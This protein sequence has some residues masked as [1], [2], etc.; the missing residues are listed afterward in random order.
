MS[1]NLDSLFV[2]TVR[3]VS[4]NGAGI[5]YP[6][7]GGFYV[8]EFRRAYPSCK[9]RI[10]AHIDNDAILL[11][12]DAITIGA[13]DVTLV[14]STTKKRKRIK[15][16]FRERILKLYTPVTVKDGNTFRTTFADGT[17]VNHPAPVNWGIDNLE[18]LSTYRDAALSK[19]NN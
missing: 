2:N 13:W 16:N 6:T 18:E 10:E 12:E 4:S 11:D 17:V 15:L 3:F 8:S 19:R 9:F 7:L 5:V 14:I 1:T